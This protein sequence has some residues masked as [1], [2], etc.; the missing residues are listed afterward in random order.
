ML[1]LLQ[2]LLVPSLAV[3]EVSESGGVTYSF[4]KKKNGYSFQFQTSFSADPACLLA[5]VFEYDH[6]S[7]FTR[8]I[9]KIQLVEGDAVRNIVRFSYDRFLFK[10]ISK[11]LRTLSKD[12]NTVTF[13]LIE[14]EL[15][16][17][18]LPKVLASKGYYKIKS[19]E[20]KATIEYFQEVVLENNYTNSFYLYFVK[21]EA[22]KFAI[23]LQQYALQVCSL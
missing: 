14:N 10:H 13:E 16:K 2:L 22:L 7:K 20:Q 23:D 5:V 12:N 21:N 4:N 3:S 15:H 9:D 1:L 17:S 19:H 11:Y 8:N 6:L 18:I